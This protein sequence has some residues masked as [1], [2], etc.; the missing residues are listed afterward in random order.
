M[1]GV[2]IFTFLCWE[3]SDYGLQPSLVISLVELLLYCVAWLIL[4]K[5]VCK[6]WSKKEDTTLGTHH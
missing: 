5:P 3:Y 1:L 4:G 6:A 2:V